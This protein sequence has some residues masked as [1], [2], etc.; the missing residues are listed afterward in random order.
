M[1]NTAIIVKQFTEK[2]DINAGE[3]SIQELTDLLQNTYKQ[4]HEEKN[5]VEYEFISDDDDAP[6]KRGRPANKPK[7]NKDGLPKIKR[8]P[9]AYNK[10][11]KLQIEEL[12]KNNPDISPKQLLP[13]AAEAWTK[14]SKEEKEEFKS[15]H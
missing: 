3:L 15:S 2:I 4:Y 6:K 9:T 10:F 5:K 12:K 1:S 11:V 8:E 13:M 14:M 7:L